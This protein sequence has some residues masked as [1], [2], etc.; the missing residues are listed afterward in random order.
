MTVRS[1]T[2]PSTDGRPRPGAAPRGA[3]PRAPPVAPRP[4]APSSS[5]TTDERSEPIEIRRPTNQ[6]PPLSPETGP[7][8]TAAPKANASA[9]SASAP[10][11]AMDGAPAR[12]CSTPAPGRAASSRPTPHPWAGRAPDARSSRRRRARAASRRSRRSRGSD[13]GPA[14][15]ARHEAH[16]RS[17]PSDLSHPASRSPERRTATCQTAHRD[18][19]ARGRA[20]Q[21]GRIVRERPGRSCR[22]VRHA[23]V[24][25]RTSRPRASPDVDVRPGHACGWRIPGRSGVGVRSTSTGHHPFDRP[26]PRSSP[27][28]GRTAKRLPP[29][30]AD[31]IPR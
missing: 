18:I 20:T 26:P 28:T 25:S 23:A 1:T 2:R 19:A 4:N 29:S 21:R 17:R 10:V 11:L 12:G 6:L 3:A 15:W 9:A 14:S 7:P 5:G 24:R 31:P 27:R 16:E 22:E 8:P 30:L 13:G